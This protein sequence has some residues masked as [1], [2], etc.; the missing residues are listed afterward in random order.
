MRHDR[1]FLPIVVC[2]LHRVPRTGTQLV[3]SFRPPASDVTTRVLTRP[4]GEILTFGFQM[5]FINLCTQR[6]A[7]KR[8]RPT[9]DLSIRDDA[10]RPVETDDTFLSV[11][12][13][14]IKLP[15]SRGPPSVTSSTTPSLAASQQ[16]GPIR[17]RTPTRP[18][19]RTGPHE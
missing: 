1:E 16:L 12:P 18:C 4:G 14:R 3:P 6:R 11:E 5:A 15:R 2:V 17:Q 10:I 8:D 19:S 13:P 9:T 7:L